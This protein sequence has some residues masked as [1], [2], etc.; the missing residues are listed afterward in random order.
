MPIVGDCTTHPMLIVWSKPLNV[1]I[2]NASQTF[3]TCRLLFHRCK[4]SRQIAAICCNGRQVLS[5]GNGWIRLIINS[6]LPPSEHHAWVFALSQL[7]WNRERRRRDL[8]NNPLNKRVNKCVDN[9]LKPL[10]MFQLAM[11]RGLLWKLSCPH[12]M[13]HNKWITRTV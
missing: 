8:Y 3:T 12:G 1:F 5:W 9:A 4:Y 13:G 7:P 11:F 6:I 2:K 10:G